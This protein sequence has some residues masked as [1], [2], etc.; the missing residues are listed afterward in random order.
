M[1]L[2]KNLSNDAQLGAVVDPD[3]IMMTENTVN[4]D[5]FQEYLNRFNGKDQLGESKAICSYQY[6]AAEEPE[7][8]RN[9]QIVYNISS[10]VTYTLHHS[11]VHPGFIRMDVRFNS[12]EDTELKLLWARLKKA[13]EAE[14]NDPDKTWIFHFILLDLGTVSSETDKNDEV[15][16]AH[17]INPVMSYLTRE[18][19]TDLA[20]ERVVNG[21]K[22]A[23]NVVR[24]LFKTEFVSLELSDQYNTADLKAEVYREAYAQEYVDNYEAP[25]ED[26]KLW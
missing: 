2:I 26:T 18:N 24:M 9:K 10:K 4:K 12:F 23:G 19:P 5:T 17:L 21:E 6:F 3:E 16:T 11:K 15:L 25:Q 22:I 8:S 7:D 13:E 14:H 20:E 1:D